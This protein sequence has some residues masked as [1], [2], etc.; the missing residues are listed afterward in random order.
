M[1]GK[2]M[3]YYREPHFFTDDHVAVA[4]QIADHVAFTLEHHRIAVA[5]EARLGAER[6]LR[7]RA[8]TEAALRQASES[9]AAVE[10]R[11]AL[12]RARLHR[13]GARGR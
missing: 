6:D 12:E 1:L 5:L 13:R 3:L 2:F 11:R 9:R 4:Q 10:D 7:Q 8:E